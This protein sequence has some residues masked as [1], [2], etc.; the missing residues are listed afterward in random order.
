MSAFTDW[1]ANKRAE[2]VVLVDLVSSTG[3]H[4]IATETWVSAPTDSPANTVWDGVIADDVVITRG[5]GGFIGTKGGEANLADIEVVNVDGAFDDWAD[6]VWQSVTVRYGDR[7]WALASFETRWSG[8]IESVEVNDERVRFVFVDLYQ[9][10]REPI[11]AV[12]FWFGQ[13]I[14]K[15]MPLSY[16]YPKNVQPPL[17]GTT[18]PDYF[19]AESG[20]VVNDPVVARYLNGAVF[21]VPA[22]V[23][24]ADAYFELDTLPQ[25]TVTVDV[26]GIEDD[27]STWIDTPGAALKHMLTRTGDVVF[28][29][30]RGGSST[31]L[32]LDTTASDQDDFYNGDTIFCVSQTKPKPPWSSPEL[33]Q[34]ITDYDGATRTVTV[35]SWDGDVA[36]RAAGDLYLII[37][38]GADTQLGPLTSAEIDSASFDAL[39]TALGDPEVGIWINGSESAEQV[40]D[41][42]LGRGAYHYPTPA[43]KLAVGLLEDPS[44][45]TADLE[46]D[47]GQTDGMIE[48]VLHQPPV[49]RLIVGYDRNFSPLSDGASS[50]AGSTE[51]SIFVR[52]EYATTPPKEDLSIRD[53]DLAAV[54][55]QLNTPL[56]SVA[57]ANTE[58]DRLWTLFSARRKVYTCAAGATPMGISPGDVI[59]LTD[60]RHGLDSGTKMVLTRIVEY[61]SAGRT[62]LRLWQ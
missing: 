12:P 26:K 39:D 47:D 19:V 15:L 59:E 27:S 53:D 29:T 17:T 20:Q 1:L 49:Y 13:D 51:R 11:Q 54:D 52:R 9:K 36:T 48:V 10:L 7:S 41:E 18:N 30:A 6:L 46:L 4:R 33:G 50:D 2:R 34:T 23:T 42:V 61:L 60:D 24:E 14:G 38:T 16:G 40:L 44:A 21:T 31:T 62:E 55:M 32:Q 43:G 28:G 25:G 22:V 3:T 58:R 37:H 57:D 45:A 56:T 5:L 8:A 35:A